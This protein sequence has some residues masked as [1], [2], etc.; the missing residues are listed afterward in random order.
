MA[1][2]QTATPPPTK[3]QGEPQTAIRRPSNQ[4]LEISYPIIP[5]EQVGRSLLP[6]CLNE[7]KGKIS[8]APDAVSRDPASPQLRIKNFDWLSLLVSLPLSTLGSA[9]RIIASSRL[10]T[11]ASTLRLSKPRHSSLFLF[12]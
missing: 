6:E 5:V 10:V 11:V 4:G 1:P 7:M 12:L 8:A 9:V 2:K 3:G